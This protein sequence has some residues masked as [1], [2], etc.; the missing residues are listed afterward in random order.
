MK[1]FIKTKSLHRMLCTLLL[2]CA[3]VVSAMANTSTYYY[4]ADVEA[5]LTNG[6]TGGGKVYVTTDPRS[7]PSY[8]SASDYTQ[9]DQDVVGDYGQ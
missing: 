7:T 4:R 1:K 3:G 8:T 6:A 2:L 9:G 5:K